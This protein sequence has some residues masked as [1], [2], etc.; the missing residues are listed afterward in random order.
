MLQKPFHHLLLAWPYSP[1]TRMMI[2]LITP[3]GSHYLQPAR[4]VS[5][6]LRHQ[7]CIRWP[8][9]RSQHREQQS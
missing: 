9:R 3:R 1:F 8:G 4:L 7:T 5:K 6:V 2:Y